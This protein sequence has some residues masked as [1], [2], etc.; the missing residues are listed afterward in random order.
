MRDVVEALA[1]F[2]IAC[3]V[4]VGAVFAVSSWWPP[5]PQQITIHVQMT[6]S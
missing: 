1:I 2:A 5:A 3:A 4:L 6:K